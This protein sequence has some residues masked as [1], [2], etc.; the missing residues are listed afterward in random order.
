[1]PRPF[2]WPAARLA[3]V[4]STSF[5]M[6]F[7]CPPAAHFH[8]SQADAEFVRQNVLDFRKLLPFGNP[9]CHRAPLCVIQIHNRF[10]RIRRDWRRGFN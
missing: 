7:R 6:S 1:V 3:W 10:S 4:G 5:G 2:S 9:L 8:V